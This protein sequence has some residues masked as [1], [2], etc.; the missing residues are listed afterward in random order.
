MQQRDRLES[1]AAG[2][3]L[4]VPSGRLPADAETL[5]FRQERKERASASMKRSL[6]LI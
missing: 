2:R 1:G 5:A 3:L 4:L 6:D